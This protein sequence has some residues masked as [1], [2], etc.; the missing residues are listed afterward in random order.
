MFD[1]TIF[2]NLK[3]VVE[4]AIYDLDLCGELQVLDRKDRVELSTMSRYYALKFSLPNCTDCCAEL[5]LWAN[6][7]DLAGEIL[8]LDNTQGKSY[9]CYLKPVFHKYVHK[10]NAEF[11]C[12]ASLKLAHKIW[13]N[14]TIVQK[15]SYTYGE[16]DSSALQEMLISFGRKF[17]EEVIEDIPTMI[18]HMV[19]ML[20]RLSNSSN[21]SHH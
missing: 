4:G 6:T 20:E 3:V 5:R 11:E 17:G 15:I 10:E 18:E 9:G 12:E 1:P 14:A 21:N 13:G 8:E 2:D 7:E 19:M 16:Y